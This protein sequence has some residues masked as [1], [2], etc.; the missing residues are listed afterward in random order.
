MANCGFL[1][2]NCYFFRY[3]VRLGET[4]QGSLQPT[5]SPKDPDV[6]HPNRT[7]SYS[8]A[9]TNLRNLLDHIG[10]DGHQ[11]SEH[12]SK[13]GAATRSSE[14]GVDDVTIQVAG[15]WQD[16]RTVRKYIDRSPL[17]TQHLMKQI[18]KL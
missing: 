4:H 1:L 2:K 15:G 10:L 9:V 6:P 7:I 5:C 16:L 3:L 14:V 11:Y 13:R 12:S 18:F 8:N 17:E